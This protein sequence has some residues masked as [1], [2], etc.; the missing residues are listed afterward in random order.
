MNQT[1]T[2][3]EIKWRLVRAEGATLP[4]ERENRALKAWFWVALVV[5]ENVALDPVHIGVGGA[6]G[7]MPPMQKVVDG[8][9]E[10]LWAML[11]SGSGFGLGKIGHC[12][13]APFDVNW[14]RYYGRF[15]AVFN[16]R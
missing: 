5:E 13:T 14:T 6:G 4:D 10:F 9:E 12:S 8:V 15:S 11:H 3:T 2:G 7:V 16:S 1:G